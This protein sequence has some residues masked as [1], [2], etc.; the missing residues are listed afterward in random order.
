MHATGA[1]NT[2]AAAARRRADI[3]GIAVVDDVCRADVARRPS[4]RPSVLRLKYVLAM[5]PGSHLS[6]R[7]SA[8]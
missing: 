2:A 5:A 1:L 3:S 7:L 8:V 6:A 4:V